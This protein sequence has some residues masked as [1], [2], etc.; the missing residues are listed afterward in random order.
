MPAGV[1]DGLLATARRPRWRPRPGRGGSGSCRRSPSRGPGGT[2][3]GSRRCPSRRC[4]RRRG[5]RCRRRG[6]RAAPVRGRQERRAA[7]HVLGVQLLDQ[8]VGA[9]HEHGQPLGGARRSRAASRIAT[10]VSTIAQSLVWSGAPAASSAS[11]SS[12]DLGGAVDLGHDDRVRPGRAP[13]REVGVVPLGA[14]AVDPDGQRAP[15]VL[16]GARRGARG[17]AGGG[18]GVGGDGVLEVEDQRRRTGIV[19]AFSSARSLELGM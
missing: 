4:R 3:R 8:V 7:G 12:R 10:G 1:L 11:T 18:L 19:L 17:V 2:R 5:S 16:A 13:R 6:R 9:H 15:A 14:D